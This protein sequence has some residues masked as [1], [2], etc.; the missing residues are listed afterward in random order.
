MFNTQDSVPRSGEGGG[1]KSRLLKKVQKHIKLVRSRHGLRHLSSR[2]DNLIEF[3]SIGPQ[4]TMRRMCWLFR[5]RY[6]DHQGNQW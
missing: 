1:A 5:K 4:R 3:S 6:R 2:L